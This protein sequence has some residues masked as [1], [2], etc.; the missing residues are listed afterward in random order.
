[1]RLHF[2]SGSCIVLATKER[3]TMGFTEDRAKGEVIFENEFLR[4]HWYYQTDNNTSGGNIYELYNKFSDPGCTR[5]LVAN[6]PYGGPGTTSALSG[7]GG[8]GTVGIWDEI[9]RHLGDNGAYASGIHCRVYEFTDTV[10]F[11]MT[12]VRHGK[13][14]LFISKSYQI[15][16][17]IIRYS[18]SSY[19]LDDHPTI[20]EPRVSFN[21]NPD[22]FDKLTWYGHRMLWPQRECA[23]PDTPGLRNLYNR[24]HELDLTDV[25]QQDECFG[26]SHTQ[27]VRFDGPHDIIK[28]TINPQGD[29]GFEQGGIFAYG[30]KQWQRYDNHMTS[31]FANRVCGRSKDEKGLWK[32]PLSYQGGLD[33]HW[34]GWWGGSGNEPSRFKEGHGYDNV[35]E[36]I[37]TIEVTATNRGKFR[38][39]YENIGWWFGG[40]R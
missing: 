23:G 28:I 15:Q 21:L 33:F 40:K 1:M 30:Y 18:V 8:I 14:I 7:I 3:T 34:F 35:I 29:K 12:L 36:D 32:I 25:T 4:I 22:K 38:A 6:Q 13:E 39:L 24:E 10:T 11:S 27:W 20:S 17:N 2:P 16:G 31:E 37:W 5:N 9:G 26:T 19:L